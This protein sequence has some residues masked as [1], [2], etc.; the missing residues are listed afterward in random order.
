MREALGSIPSVSIMAVEPHKIWKL[1]RLIDSVR[2]INVLGPRKC[3]NELITLIELTILWVPH[4]T[5]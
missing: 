1:D 2:L 3:E 5:I 4:K